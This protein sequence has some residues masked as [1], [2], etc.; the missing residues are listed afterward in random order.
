VWTPPQRRRLAMELRLDGTATP[1]RRT[2]ISKR[3][4][5]EQRPLGIP[6]Q[7]D[8]ARQTLV[9]QALEPEWEAQL[10]PHT[11]GFR[12]GRSCWEAIAAIFLRMRFRPQDALKVAI[13]KCFDRLRHAALLAKR[14]TAP[15]LRRPINAWLNAGMLE[16]GQRC[17]TTAGTP[18][19][20]SV[21][22]LLALIALHGM[23]EAL[24]QV[25]PQAR[26]IADADDGVV[27]PEDR[28]VLEHGQPLLRTWLAAMGLTLNEAK[29]R[30]QHTV[31]GGQPGFDCLGF[32]IRP[33]RVGKH[34]SGRHAAGHRLGSKTLIN[35]AKANIQAHLAALGRIMRRSKALP[36]SDLIRQLNPKIRGWAH[37][38]RSGVRQA[39]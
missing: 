9:R 23:D 35:P 19:G 38:Y 29:S 27:L 13:A 33:Y 11:Y 1:L 20:G 25:D 12:P 7:G 10:A 8:R 5:P 32:H 16:A 3:G 22:P 24:T 28:R 6:T 26:V 34:P 21:S 14:Q 31:E 39:G 18:Q 17:P 2:W 4:S 36:Q 15:G 37:D 30:I